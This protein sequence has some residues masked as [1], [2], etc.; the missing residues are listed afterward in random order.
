M[1][2]DFLNQF[3]EGFLFLLA[4]SDIEPAVDRIGGELGFGI[5][6]RKGPRHRG[7]LCGRKWVVLGRLAYRIGRID[8]ANNLF[9]A[10]HLF[11]RGSDDQAVGRRVGRGGN[12]FRGRSD[13]GS[14]C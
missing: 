4:R 6:L 2:V 7:R 5:A 14:K 10:L 3:P 1:R 12:P 11:G 8:L 9:D 13:R